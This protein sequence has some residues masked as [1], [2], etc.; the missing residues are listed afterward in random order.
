MRIRRL[1][2]CLSRREGWKS[3]TRAFRTRVWWRR[4]S[5][6]PSTCVAARARNCL[7]LFC[8]FVSRNDPYSRITSLSHAFANI[9]YL[10]V[11]K[12]HVGHELRSRPPKNMMRYMSR[13]Q[14][15]NAVTKQGVNQQ[16]CPQAGRTQIN[17]QAPSHSHHLAA[18]RGQVTPIR[19][20]THRS[21]HQASHHD[22]APHH[23]ITPHCS[24]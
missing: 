3:S 19:H 15:V 13:T 12:G 16:H 7:A 9:S 24:Q 22:H 14:T 17:T 6:R 21:H 11:T 4:N 5:P 10:I 1:H 23:E 2:V 18:A 8:S 20:Q